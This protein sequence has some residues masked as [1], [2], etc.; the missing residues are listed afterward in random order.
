MTYTDEELVRELEHRYPECPLVREVCERFLTKEAERENESLRA[1]L[2][3]AADDIADWGRYASEYFQE[4]HGLSECVE[5]YRLA[6]A[7][8]AFEDF[9]L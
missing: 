8:V 1:L 6:K 3:E 9:G 7:S 4:K 5:K 2:L